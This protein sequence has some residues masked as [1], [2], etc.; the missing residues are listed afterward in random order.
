MTPRGA[1][2]DQSAINPNTAVIAK[3]KLT[4][5]KGALIALLIRQP[6]F[7]TVAPD[8]S[9]RNLVEIARA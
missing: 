7:K 9:A 3:V 8:I 5:R 2:V 1:E 4:D 6:P